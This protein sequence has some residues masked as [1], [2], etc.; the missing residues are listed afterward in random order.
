MKDRDLLKVIEML[1]DECSSRDR[2]FVKKFRPNT[3]NH[4]DV[5]K[6][7]TDVYLRYLSN[8]A[9]NDL[10]VMVKVGMYVGY[11][12][13]DPAWTGAKKETSFGDLSSWQNKIKYKTLSD[14]ECIKYLRSKSPTTIIDYIKK[15][16]NMG[17]TTNRS[18]T[19]NRSINEATIMKRLLPAKGTIEVR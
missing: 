16:V 10:V 12:K 9:L 1:Y 18:R 19:L 3:L 7:K 2:V 11:G 4:P 13:N 15:Y 14:D 8:E 17:P 6:K 5:C